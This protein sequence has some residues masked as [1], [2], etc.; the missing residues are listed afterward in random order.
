[1]LFRCRKILRTVARR[2][3]LTPKLVVYYQ[4]ITHQSSLTADILFI[5]F[6]YFVHA[7]IFVVKFPI[8]VAANPKNTLVKI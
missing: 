4:V 3:W 7:M 5:M 6:V 8:Y 2:F 1:M